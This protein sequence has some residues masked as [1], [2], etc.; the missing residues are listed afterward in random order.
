MFSF[1]CSKEE[2]QQRTESKIEK[3][4]LEI[5]KPAV[6]G[7]YEV[8]LLDKN[9]IEYKQIISGRPGKYG[10]KIVLSLVSSGPKTFN[11]WA[12]TDATSSSIAGTMFA[13]LVE[14][15]PWNGEIIPNLAKDFETKQEGREILVHLRKGIKWSDGKLIT[16]RDVIFTWNTILKD[17]LERLGAR[18]SLLVNGKF[19][20]VKAFDEYTVSFKTERVFAPLLSELGYPIA[21]AHYFEP[22]LDE[23]SKGLVGEAKLKKLREV[24]SSLWGTN[25]NPKSLIVSGP[26]VITNYAKGERVEMKA[27][28]NYFVVD[29]EG[30]KLPYFEGITHQIIPSGD[31]ELFKFISGEFLYISLTPDTLDLLK[32]IP[33]KNRFSVYHEG[34]SE[35]SIFL[36]FNMS[37]SSAGKNVRKEASSWFNNQKFREAIALGIDRQ[38]MIDSIYQGIGS[39]LCFSTSVNSI[40]FDKSLTKQCQAKPQLQKAQELLKEA[41]FKLDK[42]KQLRDSKGNLVSFSIYT[43]A[44]GATDTSSPRELMAVL[45]KEQL[46]KLGIKV[47]IKVIEF[48]NLV[49]RIMQSGDW[50]TCIMG[51][52]GG[53]LFE[54]NSSANFLYSNSRLHIFDQRKQGTANDTRDWEREIDNSLKQ[55]T[56]FLDFEQRKKFYYKIQNIL[57]EQ[58]PLIYLATPD[59]LVAVQDEKIGNFAPSKLSGLA[60]NIEQWYWK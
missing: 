7:K 38:A 32:Q 50:E 53:D 39:P 26:F 40:Y 27:N 16:S 24:F 11:Y 17:G 10:G 41:G 6:S 44:S 33:T 54:P 56:G 14:R 3:L 31:L 1:G 51:L 42:N 35:T 49:V 22:I 59:V 28:P 29:E 13:G 58:K 48:N 4:K 19:P 45:I 12:S 57:W 25:L 21:P 46:K 55:G 34:P 60:Y 30:N 18:E 52:T 9:G 15:N 23:A 43:N 47:E 36:A 8:K 2:N 37:R 5:K 20:E